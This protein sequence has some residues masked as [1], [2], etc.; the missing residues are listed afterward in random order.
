MSKKIIDTIKSA[1]LMWVSILVPLFIAA[2]F[3]NTFSQQDACECIDSFVMDEGS[4]ISRY[5][6]EQ[7]NGV[8]QQLEFALSQFDDSD[9]KDQ[10]TAKEA[11]S[12]VQKERKDMVSITVYD[13]KGKCF[14]SSTGEVHD[15]LNLQEE[16]IKK[17]GDKYLYYV[18]QDDNTHN[19]VLKFIV[20]RKF[21]D[22]NKDGMYFELIVKWDQ[23]EKYMKNMQMGVFPRMFYILSP[24]CRRY[25]S[26]N[27]LPPQ[28]KS[29]KTVVALGLHLASK[30]QSIKNGLSEVSISGKI[31]KIF[32]ENIAIPEN[33]EGSNLFVVIAT[34]GL[35]LSAI[36]A[37]L[38]EGL[39]FVFLMLVVCCML[40]CVSMSKFYSKT[41]DQLEVSTAIAAS[42]PLAITIFRIADGNIKQINLAAMTM[43]RI[44]KDAVSTINMWDVFISEG[45]MNYVHNA[46]TSNIN[47]LNYEVLI[48][49]FGGGNFWSICSA[50]PVEIEE[51]KCVVLAILDINSRK[52]AERRL[53]HN[54]EFLENE[55][56]ER[57]ADMDKKAKE[58]EESN[59]NLAR[60]R[61][62]ADRANTYKSLFLTSMSNELRTPIN[63]IKGYSDILK[64]EAL[65]RKD[66]VSAEDLRKVMGSANHL[67]SLVDEIMN[68]SMI[69][70]GKTQMYF[71][72]IDITEMIKDVEGV[73]MPLIAD[74]DNSLFLEYPKDIG[75]MYTDATKL[76]QCLLNLLGNASK[77]T[78][79]GR[80]TLRAVPVDKDG[81]SF[82]EFTV[83]DTGAGMP[84]KKTIHLFDESEDGT[85]NLGMGLSLTKKYV[86]FFG[87]TIKAESTEGMG[88]KFIIDVPRT[89][90]AVSSE[91]LYVKN[92][93]MNDGAT[94]PPPT[95]EDVKEKVKEETKEV[96]PKE[97][98]V[99]KE[100]ATKKEAEKEDS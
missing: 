95:E 83:I 24:D 27:S 73:V 45:D 34:D 4:G 25:I 91:F 22:K 59:A 96:A 12:R 31:F 78:E 63:A 44:A 36:S 60:E 90:T 18:G 76:R 75:E 89:T 93:H 15:D 71:E 16:R 61:A 68:L 62:A 92:E 29:E 88:S 28:V 39:S 98:V 32:K 97:E 19:I 55:V 51:Q 13:N 11:L 6:G 100:D 43:M 3:V 5:V 81:I 47:I 37:N 67:M 57:T 23:H 86:N 84:S 1:V 58:L 41:K 14:S 99:V 85:T 9:L 56:K 53:A 50:S 38:N 70:S 26:L 79:F 77:F 46:I 17:I 8:K 69:E 82:I 2:Y 7:L 54:A 49:S 40:L 35:A 30:V 52:E 72:K 64:E 20:L 33:L 87:G 94:P 42:T 80:I 48:Q 74:N 65:E 21:K 10:K 66:A